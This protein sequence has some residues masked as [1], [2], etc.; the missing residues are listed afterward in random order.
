MEKQSNEQ[1]RRS[2]EEIFYFVKDENGKV[3]IVCA[4]MQASRKKFDTFEQAEAYIS[5][6]PY[7]LIFNTFFIMQKN[8]EESKKSE[9]DTENAK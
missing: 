2:K 4:G 3:V 9:S 6:K 8:Y 5:T 7:E 1:V